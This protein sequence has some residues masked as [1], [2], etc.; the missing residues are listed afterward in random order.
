MHTV[1]EALTQV[2]LVHASEQSAT[3]LAGGLEPHGMA[4]TWVLSVR[5]AE[6]LV[7][8]RGFD[9]TVLSHL[10]GGG[11]RVAACAALRQHRDTPPLLL[12]DD[13][14]GEELSRLLPDAMRPA[15]QLPAFV[16]AEKLAD[17]IRALTSRSEADS[18]EEPELARLS[19]PE[20]LV[21]LRDAGE[22]GTLEIRNDGVVTNIHISNGSPVFAE[23]GSLRETLGRMLLRRGDISEE[24]FVKVIER[25]TEQLH[26]SEPLRMGEVL[27]ELGLLGPTDVY[28]ALNDQVHEK[29]VAC[30]QW[31]RFS[32]AFH[33]K[34]AIPEGLR[35]FDPPPLEALIA[36]GVKFHFDEERA[37]RLL[38]DWASVPRLTEKA[39]ALL[40]RLRLSGPEQ[41]F[42]RSID[43]TRSFDSLR[44][45]S[46]I[47]A[48]AAAQ[49]LAVLVVTGVVTPADGTSAPSH[50]TASGAR[51]VGTNAVDAIRRPAP[52]PRP[53]SAPP[54]RDEARA[55]LDAERLFREGHVLL[56]KGR[57]EQAHKALAEA[58]RLQ[59][60]EPEYAMLESWTSYLL[61]R[62]AVNLA[63]AKARACAMRMAQLDP[64]SARPHSILGRLALDE[65]RFE[66][67]TRELEAALLRDPEDGDA[68]SGMRGVE[69]EGHR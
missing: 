11:D 62:V 57:F 66:Q 3:A 47:G 1:S 63:R 29:I 41:R 64:Q 19:L 27:I 7:R 45:E 2:L 44:R 4:V 26:E 31:P 16:D 42:L 50:P 60:K 46:N 21:S 67:A 23:G 65:R 30:F 20:I 9:V 37:G 10:A 14:P 68:K 51:P 59:P 49:L 40:P 15:A 12:M 35:T 39:A 33:P 55:R 48:T 38:G 52:T 18:S 28:Q 69:A 24:E 36:E 8:T 43:G 58:V 54:R 13:A 61:Q 34:D 53:A 5:E 6:E 17:E 25:M 56:E 32:P 22:T